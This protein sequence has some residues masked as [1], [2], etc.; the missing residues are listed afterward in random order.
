[1]KRINRCLL[2]VIFLAVSVLHADTDDSRHPFLS[3]S[4]VI[5]ICFGYR[6]K[7]HR[8]DLYDSFG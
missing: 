5:D 8:K 6:K 2:F 4:E 1:M 7:R 3:D